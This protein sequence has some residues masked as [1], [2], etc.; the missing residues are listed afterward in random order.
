MSW[1]FEDE[2]DAVSATVLERLEGATA[3]VPAIWPFEVANVLVVAMRRRRIVRAAA[4]HFLALLDELPI[5]IDRGPAASE[6]FRLAS[7]LGLSSY[8]AA[9]IELAV[10]TGLPLATRDDRVTE[11][12]GRIGVVTL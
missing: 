9:Y 3:H 11:A 7:E 2:S 8:D 12:A 6:V 1:C 4:E 5:V 10:R